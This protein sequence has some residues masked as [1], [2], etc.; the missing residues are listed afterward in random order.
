MLFE[1]IVTMKVERKTGKNDV[2]KVRAR[3]RL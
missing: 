2:L 1:I 3:K